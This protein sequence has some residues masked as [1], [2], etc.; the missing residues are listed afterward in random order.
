[1]DGY[2][3]AGTVQ[4]ATIG[5]GSTPRMK[6]TF[7]PGSDPRLFINILGATAVTNKTVR[8]DGRKAAETILMELARHQEGNFS[9][10]CSFVYDYDSD[11]LEKV[12]EKLG[13]ISIGCKPFLSRI[14]RVCRKLEQYGILSGRVSSCHAEYI[15][16]PRVLKKYCFGDHSYA[17]RLAPDLWPNY[18]PM[19]QV[20]TELDF[21][22][23]N[24]FP[25][26]NSDDS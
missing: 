10:C 15:G 16:E 11:F 23:R 7:W 8:V 20:E 17:M 24:A 25:R 12:A 3:L 1:M 13:L 19:G 9:F 18:R 26:K 2:V 22:L 4:N 21:L 6:R 14:Q 5:F